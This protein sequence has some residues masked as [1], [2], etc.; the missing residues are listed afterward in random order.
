MKLKKLTI[1]LSVVA[2]ATACTK[3]EQKPLNE[4]MLGKWQ[5]KYI[6]IDM[7]TAANTDS[8]IVF[9]EKFDKPNPTVAQS[10]YKADGTFTSWF[11]KPD[12]TKES[13][14]IGKWETKGDS[15]FV[16]YKH[17]GKNVKAWYYIKQLKNGFE[18]T[19]VHDWDWDN[20]HDDTL[21]M[22]SEKLQ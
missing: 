21:F 20:E 7:P 19:S 9:E 11:L 15:L 1:L 16:D 22:K 14:T 8:T 6:K 2:M 3:T 13:E 18:G 5:T 17:I 12:G 10:I 4:F